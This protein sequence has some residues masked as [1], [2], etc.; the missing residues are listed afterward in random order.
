[1]SPEVPTESSPEA[2]DAWQ[3]RRRTFVGASVAAGGAVAT[4]GLLN[5]CSADEPRADYPPYWSTLILGT[6]RRAPK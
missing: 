2:P 3:I 6:Q 5:G 4:I 1:M